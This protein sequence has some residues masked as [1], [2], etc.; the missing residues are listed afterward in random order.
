MAKNRNTEWNLIKQ[1]LNGQADTFFQD[2][3]F[4]GA[5]LNS[6]IKSVRL[7][8]KDV[9]QR[10]DGAVRYIDHIEK[11]YREYSR[12]QVASAIS[13]M[14]GANLFHPEWIFESEFCSLG[15]MA[16]WILDTLRKCGNLEKAC[17]IING[18]DYDEL[19][20][21]DA[22]TLI[23]KGHDLYS[24]SLLENLYVV[25]FAETEDFSGKS[26]LGK[27]WLEIRALIPN[28]EIERVNGKAHELI[29]LYT[30]CTIE[31]SNYYVKKMENPALALMV[32]PQDESEV[33]NLSVQFTQ[34]HTGIALNL[35][36]YA[37][38]ELIG[39]EFYKRMEPFYNAIYKKEID[40]FGLCA[41]Y[42]LKVEKEDCYSLMLALPQIVFRAIFMLLPWHTKM[43][44]KNMDNVKI[45]RTVL[46]AVDMGTYHAVYFPVYRHYYPEDGAEYLANFAQYY[47][48]KNE[49]I[50]P[51]EDLSNS[52]NDFSIFSDELAEKLSHYD[53]FVS[54]YNRTNELDWIGINDESVPLEDE[55][56][57]TEDDIDEEIIEEKT[58][59]ETN[60][61]E[62]E[63]IAL[64]QEIESLK[65]TIH[66][67]DKSY[68][69]LE[70]KH[71]YLRGE[72]D[73]CHKAMAELNEAIFNRENGEVVA[74]SEEK[75]IE[76]SLPY[77]AKKK[78][79]VFGG[80]ATWLKAIK[81]MLQNVKFVNEGVQ[82]SIELVRNAEIVW[83]QS[84]AISHSEYYKIMDAVRLYNKPCHYFKFS[85]AL[86]CA[87]QF[88][89]VDNEDKE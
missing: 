73:K 78:S 60:N 86:K 70:R 87:K 6:T 43:I 67:Q 77:E 75:E 52:M 14:E 23:V 66:S 10:T 63:N 16:I 17:E 8:Q 27:Y 76:K 85:S 3:K 25:L 45:D 28:E 83:I 46:D 30:K 88:I 79:V 2:E 35:T 34:L 24:D 13:F 48:L 65:R 89:E 80:H 37:F 1:L 44:T 81:P 57:E 47:F 42:C 64:K 41:A 82:F 7:T 72:Y 40:L 32:N 33:A 54:L 59:E 56:E 26:I 5:N 9:R 38:R 22:P 11:K 61:L 50:L 12:E 69:L 55:I 49:A 21:V 20:Q 18:I 74:S 68:R 84:N 71:E 15:G 62:T 29:D 19:G 39:N 36:T 53:K 51:Y 4:K 31:C 58:V